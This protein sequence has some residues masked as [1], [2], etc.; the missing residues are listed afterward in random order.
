MFAKYFLQ[1]LRIKLLA[2]LTL[3]VIISFIA[4]AL[5]ISSVQG[6]RLQ[7][8]GAQVNEG[9]KQSNAALQKSFDKM[10]KEIDQ[11]MNQMAASASGELTDYTRRAL[12][13]QKQDIA[14]EWNRTLEENA[15]SLSNILAQVAPKDILSNNFFELVNYVKSVSKN[16][17]VVYAFYI[18]PDGDFYTR[19]LNNNDEK[20]KSYIAKGEGIKR[21][22]KVLNASKQDPTVFIA[23]SDIEMEGKVL[24]KVV[25]CMD[26]T[27]MNQKLDMVAG[28]FNTLI[29]GSSDAISATLGRESA[30]VTK[31][32]TNVV[33]TIGAEN[34]G[35]LKQTQDRIVE[36]AQAVR[37]HTRRIVIMAGFFCGA[38]L[39]GCVALLSVTLLI[40]PVEA[41]AKRLEDIAQG[42]GD[43]SKRL[44]VKS[45]D[46]VGR[47]A[48]WFNVF[49]DKL[50]VIISAVAQN[51]ETVSAS[52]EKLTDI[53]KQMS[54]GAA[55][56]SGQSNTVSAAAEQMSANII[57]VAAASEQAATNMS[58]VATSAEEMSA[59][60]NE[61]AQNS[62][63]ARSISG[64]A[65][66]HVH[67]TRAK[68]D[69]LG[70]AAT[71]IGKVTEIIT[72]ISAQTNLLALNAT[73]EA[74]RA[75]EAGKGFAVV[76]NEI[77]ELAKQTAEATLDIKN[78]VSGIQCST[79]ET[80]D[81]I[82]R[83]QRVIE[84]V[85]NTVAT[86][87]TAVEEQSVTTKEIAEN[88]GQAAH[89]IQSVNESIAQSSTVAGEI[90]Q[91]I[92]SVN[93][94]AEEMANASQQVNLGSEELS[95]L[96]GELQ[97]MIGG[98]KVDRDCAK[99]QA[100]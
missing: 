58:M 88:V 68:I 40:K 63:K 25:L 11:A 90:A 99:S 46:E 27:A 23:Q 38:L 24:G 73:I 31:A 16:P 18:K 51:A 94:G 67:Q 13:K 74:A 52:A 62:E 61:V 93:A 85:N 87:A 4:L 5:I 86:I 32:I 41:V 56:M 100:A 77:K 34:A 49:V 92:S 53:S 50:Q 35:L 29:A 57:S 95:R 20:I 7:Q 1:S 36:A 98:F 59:T 82:G 19:Y 6:K 42:E 21:Y 65:V 17:D 45:M 54:S 9:L 37:S 79:G 84:E 28:Q 33:A 75:G 43:L 30:N 97:K 64:Q 83:I 72:D 66:S 2:P 10:G 69:T 14:T 3:L 60:I 39:L 12:D 47:L 71:A 15:K 55:A 81:E 8:M 70:V 22:D 76:A 80:V 89:G 96:S 91:D 48:R 26:K 78:Q 44:Q